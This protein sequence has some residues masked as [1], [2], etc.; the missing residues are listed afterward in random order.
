MKN[1]RNDRVRGCT[2]QK[3]TR[4]GQMPEKKP[5]QADPPVRPR[6]PVQSPTLAPGL[7]ESIDRGS[8]GPR[9]EAVDELLEPITHD[10]HQLPIEL[11]ERPEILSLY[12][13]RRVARERQLHLEIRALCGEV[14]R[15]FNVLV[16][17]GCPGESSQGWPTSTR[18]STQAG[19]PSG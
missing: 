3:M 13:V 2:V 15:V 4:C 10:L 5:P 16:D 1:S 6:S 14:G 18:V 9:L 19:D 8:P 17:H 12:A 7:S 11:L